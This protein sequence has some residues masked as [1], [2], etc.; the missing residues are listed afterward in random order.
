MKRADV[1]GRCTIVFAI[2]SA[3]CCGCGKGSDVPSVDAAPSASTSAAKV[4]LEA[5]STDRAWVEARTGDP[6][7]LA[8]L[9]DL[10]GTGALAAVADNV[11][12]SEDDRAAALR[13]LAFVEDA[14]PA[15]DVLTRMVVGS[16]IERSTLAL[17]TLA[18]VASRRA[19]IEEH[20]PS[21]W[22][23]CGRVLIAAMKTIGE[24]VRRGLVRRVLGGIV[25]RG[26]VEAGEV[27]G[28]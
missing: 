26:A 9:A 7:E 8:R 11:A 27:P 1:L 2:V 15:L 19:P 23:A 10:E 5:A 20:D 6:L 28:E 16:S 4:T 22:G 14:T 25:E 21:A 24:P 13:A 18:A 3:C 17:Q 12:A